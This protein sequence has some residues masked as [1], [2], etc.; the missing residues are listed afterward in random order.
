MVLLSFSLIIFHLNKYVNCHNSVTSHME[1]YQGGVCLLKK[2]YLPPDFEL[3]DCD[4][5]REK[6]GYCDD[7]KE[8][9]W[10]WT[11]YFF[12]CVIILIFYDIFTS[13][14]FKYIITPIYEPV[15]RYQET[16]VI[17][18]ESFK[19]IRC[20]ITAG[21]FVGSCAILFF[22]FFITLYI[23]CY[24]EERKSI[25]KNDYNEFINNHMIKYYDGMCL[26]EKK[27]LPFYIKLPDCDGELKK[28]KENL[29]SCDKEIEIHERWCYYTYVHFVSSFILPFILLSITSLFFNCFLVPLYNPLWREQATRRILQQQATH[30]QQATRQFKSCSTKEN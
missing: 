1:K 30:R 3:P 22:T 14:L 16:N 23:L 17:N 11:I 25:C 29:Y 26:L 6:I 24:Y 5:E 2:K 7:D 8:D 27:Y 18:I 4:K 10:S 20:D 28:I 15:W 13:I 21:P 19:H 12:C 9:A